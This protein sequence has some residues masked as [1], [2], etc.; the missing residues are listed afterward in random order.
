MLL[1]FFL[2]AISMCVTRMD[3]QSRLKLLLL[4]L[5][6]YFVFIDFF[7]RIDCKCTAPTNEPTCKDGGDYAALKARC[8]STAGNSWDPVINVDDDDDDDVSRMQ[9]SVYR[10]ICI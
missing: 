6:S 9:L 8:L 10:S 2:V 5:Y 4:F 3:F 1:F 7:F